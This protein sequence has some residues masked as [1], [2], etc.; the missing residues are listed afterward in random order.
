[1]RSNTALLAAR[2]DLLV[3]RSNY[4]RADLQ[5][6]AVGVGQRLRLVDRAVAFSR[7]ASGRL[8]LVGGA[9]LFVLAG[10]RKLLSVAGRLY[11]VWRVVSR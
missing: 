5:C 9:A 7:S 8:L 11:A 10:P 6:E 1:V 2:R 3:A 4:L